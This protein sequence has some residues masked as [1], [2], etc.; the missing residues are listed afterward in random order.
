MWGQLSSKSKASSTKLI[1]I[2]SLTVALHTKGAYICQGASQG[3]GGKQ[4]YKFLRQYEYG[5]G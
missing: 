1:L 3:G 2:I 5:G 4:D